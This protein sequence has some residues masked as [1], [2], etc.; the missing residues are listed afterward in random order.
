MFTYA[1]I[2]LTILELANKLFDYGQQQK[3]INEGQSIEVAKSA[4]EILRKSNY[5]KHAIEEF[6]AK[7]DSDVDEFLRSL[8]PS[9]PSNSK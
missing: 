4:A 8:E 1:Q 5:A 9:E 3:W 7:S 2:V 6:T